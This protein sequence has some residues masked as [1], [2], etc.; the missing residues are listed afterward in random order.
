MVQALADEFQFLDLTSVDKA[1]EEM[2]VARAKLTLEYSRIKV[3]QKRIAKRI[4]M[5]G[6][7]LTRLQNQ[8]ALGNVILANPYDERALQVLLKRRSERIRKRKIREAFQRKKRNAGLQSLPASAP[9][10]NQPSN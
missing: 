10:D 4:G 3:K 9:E 5:L 8:L 7:G 1:F 2:R 6:Q